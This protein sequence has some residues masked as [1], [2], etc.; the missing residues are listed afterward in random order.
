MTRSDAA[1]ALVRLTVGRGRLPILGPLD[2]AFEPGVLHLV[3]GP[4]GCGK[5]TLIQTIAGLLP[6]VSGEIIHPAH[7]TIAYSGQ[8][9]EREPSLPMTVFEVVASGLPRTDRRDAVTRALASVDLAGRARS[10]FSELSGGQRRRVLIARALA[11]RT[12]VLLLDEPTSELD[13]AMTRR[14][15][16]SLLARAR[17][18]QV[19]IAATHALPPQDL[20]G[21]W[22]ELRLPSAGAP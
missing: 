10:R 20:E 14:I 8:T 2:D 3:T 16:A 18:G 1:I 4:N 5:S 11:R 22:G 12:S 17:E 7:T 15:W 21:A 9:T 6:A 19:V 13:P